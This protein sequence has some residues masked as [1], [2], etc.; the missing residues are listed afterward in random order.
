MATFYFIRCGLAAASSATD[1]ALCKHCITLMH[2]HDQNTLLKNILPVLFFVGS[3]CLH[4][5]KVKSE[6]AF[7]FVNSKSSFQYRKARCL[8]HHD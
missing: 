8:F 3:F 2:K 4:Y 1:S 5:G 7:F 6:S